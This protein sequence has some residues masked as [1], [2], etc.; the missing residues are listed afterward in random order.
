M[1][2]HRLLAL[3]LACILL[4]G[5]ELWAQDLEHLQIH[6]FATQGFLFSTNNN[7]MTMHSSS[8]SLQWTEGAVNF[9]DSISD[10][11]RVGIQLHMYQMGQIGGPEVLVDWVS[12]DYKVNDNLGFRAGKIK[13]PMGL[14]ND[15]Q[16]VDSLFL[17]TLLPQAIYPDD[18]RD[19]DLAALGGELYGSLDLERRGRIRYRGFAGE[20]RLDANGGYMLTL[21]EYGFTFATPPSGKVFGGD[22]RWSGALPGLTFGASTQTQA[23]D[24]SGPQGTVHMPAFFLT[25]Y[26]AE[27][28]KGKWYVAGEYWRI[29]ITVQLQ[30]GPDTLWMPVDQRAWY[31]MVS[32]QLTQRLQVGTYYSHSVIK[33]AN[34]SL[35]ENYSKDWAI[36]GRYNFN[37]NLYG[38]IEGHFLH[39]N[40]IGYYSA[41]NPDGLKP[42]TAILAARIGFTF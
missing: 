14:F 15:S 32:Y 37:A 19:F 29:P 24:G 39:G 40:E 30:A 23:L 34:T 1:P 16:D 10:K 6:G 8:G 35:P 25:A 42:N 17:W 5:G 13:I 28:S 20:N 4:C 26:F 12:A 36:S 3:S 31:P 11:M 41:S 7:Y 38:K 27:W 18:N 2:S 33:G 9:S 22:L 21:A